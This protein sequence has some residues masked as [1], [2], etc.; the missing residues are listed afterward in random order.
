MWTTLWCYFIS[1]E[2][3]SLT[4]G[5]AAGSTGKESFNI[6]TGADPTFDFSLSLTCGLYTVTG[7]HHFH[8]NELKPKHQEE[9]DLKMM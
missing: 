4:R 3:I 9:T 7:L 8:R 5:S 2:T 6:L 1:P